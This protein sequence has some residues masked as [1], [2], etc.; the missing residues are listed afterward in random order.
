DLLCQFFTKINECVTSTNEVLDLTE[1][2]VSVGLEEEVVKKLMGLIK[3]GTIEK[4]INVNLFNTLTSQLEHKANKNEN[5]NDVIDITVYGAVGDGVSD[6][7]YAL[8]LA[9]EHKKIIFFPQNS[10]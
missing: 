6:T 10:R 8:N 5:R 2:L 9:K 3:D 1:W 4:L 7:S